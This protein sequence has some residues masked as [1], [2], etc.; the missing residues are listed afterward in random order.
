MAS[1]SPMLPFRFIATVN[2]GS[3]GAAAH[4]AHERPRP[5][6][7]IGD[8]H[9][10]AVQRM[11]VDV[12]RPLGVV[13]TSEHASNHVPAA[14][15][16]RLRIGRAH[17]LSHRGFDRG[18]AEMARALASAIG[19]PL[20]LGRVSRLVVDL[21]RSPGNRNLWSSQAR[22]LPEEIRDALLRRHHTPHWEQVHALVQ[23]ERTAGRRVLHVGVH[24]FTPVL[25]G[26]VR[27][28]DVA[29]LYDPGRAFEVAIVEAW[30]EA[31]RRRAPD[32][33]VRRNAPYRGIDDGLTRALRRR[34]PDRD[35]AGIELELNQGRLRSGRFP[36]AFV[37]AI[38][39]SLRDALHNEGERG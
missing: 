10:V 28:M 2:R 36:V 16:P 34:F 7:R 17:L 15:A 1:I 18:A 14:V 8:W 26:N 29:F 27:T 30:R 21:N 32:L 35:Y 19:A 6:R 22:A 5:R 3:S 23:R 31:L 33:V 39:S 12:P 11:I 38:V 24:S 37:Q 9:A 13:V 4:S 20:V 25:R